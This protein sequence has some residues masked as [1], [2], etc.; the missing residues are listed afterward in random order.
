M[1]D[2]LYM[3]LQLPQVTLLGIDCVNVE[4]LQAALDASQTGIEFGAVKLLT[5]LPTDDPRLV[6]IPHL[7]TMDKYSQFCIEDLAK[8]VDTEYMIMIQYD[9]FILHPEL[10]K[11]EFLEYD[12]IGGPMLT[13]G[14]TP[15]EGYPVPTPFIVGNGG[16]TLR[17]KKFLDLCAQF[18]AD[19]TITNTAP[20]DAAIS[21]WYRRDFEAK[22]MK[23]PSI[24][25]AMEFCV[26]TKY[27]EEYVKGFGFHSFYAKNM[28]ALKEVF[29]NY[30][31]YHFIPRIRWGRLM[32]L[33][34]ACRDVAVSGAFIANRDITVPTVAW[35]TFKDED[36][37]GA[38]DKRMTYI[39]NM[40]DVIE[41]S[42]EGHDISFVIQTRV[43]QIP[44]VVHFQGVSA[45]VPAEAQEFLR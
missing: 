19:G 36:L 6:T 1:I 11:P 12:Y 7:D 29:P 21:Y 3:K 10:W 28:E 43:G 17:S 25:L 42:E 8:Y 32:L 22:G 23:Y 35:L 16:F 34:S 37:E 13:H 24:E 5:S 20:E 26:N 9:G 44:Y 15:I 38:W 33:K 2:W 39:E 45:E 30:P 41:S 4:R 18:V 14:W 31:M 40:G 27:Q